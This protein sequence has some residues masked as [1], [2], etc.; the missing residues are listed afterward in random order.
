MKLSF[1]F[2]NLCEIAITQSYHKEG[3]E[4]LK[5]KITRKKIEKPH[6]QI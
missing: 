1:F 6:S 2:A 3:T 5:K 4:F